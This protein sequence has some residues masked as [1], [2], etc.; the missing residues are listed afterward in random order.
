ML[1]RDGTVGRMKGSI[2]VTI[3]LCLAG[4]RIPAGEEIRVGSKA[5][6]L[7]LESVYPESPADER[8]LFPREG[9]SLVLEFWA[10]WC[11]PCLPA[12]RHLNQIAKALEDEPVDF[13]HV[14]DEE[15]D[16]VMSFVE[17]RPV[18][19]LVGCDTDRSAFA[20][21]NVTYRPHTVLIDA[22]GIVRGIPYAERLDEGA[23]RDLIQGRELKIEERRE[24][25][26]EFPDLFKPA[27]GALFYVM[28]RRSMA[29][30]KGIQ[31]GPGILYAQNITL[32]QV[33]SNAY[34]VSTAR[35]R[36]PSELSEIGLDVAVS[37]GRDR[38]QRDRVIVD[39]LSQALGIQISKKREKTEVFLLKA[40]PGAADRLQPAAR[41]SMSISIGGGVL[42]A[43]SVSLD[44]LAMA[45]EG[46]LRNPVVNR[47][48]L[49]GRY[50]VELEW[51][52][53]DASAI[54]GALRGK[55]SLLL[56]PSSESVEVIRVERR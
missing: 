7:N 24:F 19:G 18:E 39:A 28:V 10:T 31:T 45:L 26:D 1:M 22:N 43:L 16:S 42:S 3:L 38:E 53:G 40:P 29:E 6:T 5:P 34:R 46:V 41:G 55:Y 33:L 30:K 56:E 49:A 21:Y 20:D 52:A 17:N 12:M 37:V 15:L 14:T 25:S 35:V 13:L 32:Q 44:E 47:T 36:A 2:L 48:G 50:D 4:G 8:T 23:I 51:D 9:R 11:G 54:M 27:P